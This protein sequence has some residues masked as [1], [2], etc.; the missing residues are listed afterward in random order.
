MLSPHWPIPLK[1][2]FAPTLVEPIPPDAAVAETAHRQAAHYV[3]AHLPARIHEVLPLLGLKCG[4]AMKIIACITETAVMQAILGHPGEPTSPPRLRPAQ[5][6]QLW[7]MAHAL[8]DE[9]N[10][11]A[12]PAPDYMFDQRIA[13]QGNRRTDV[14]PRGRL[15]PLA[16][17]AAN[18]R[19]PA[20]E[21]H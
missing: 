17:Q 8:P 14:A 21:R 12:Q 11:Q 19:R 15:V 1:L 6:P 9:S 18:F 3:W 7:E 2:P 13:W 5:G 10:P 20:G 4:G 16:T